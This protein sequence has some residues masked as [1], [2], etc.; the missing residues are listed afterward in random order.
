MTVVQ[1]PLFLLMLALCCSWNQIIKEQ[2]QMEQKNYF[3]EKLAIK[4][5]TFYSVAIIVM[6]LILFYLILVDYPMFFLSL[7]TLTRDTSL[8][9]GGTWG[10]YLNHALPSRPS[11]SYRVVGVGWCSPFPL[12]I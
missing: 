8:T 7:S 9:L 1:A 12:R 5:S 6:I 3:Q 2:R 10:I 11:K 4:I